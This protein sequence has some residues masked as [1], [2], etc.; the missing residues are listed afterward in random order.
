[1]FKVYD[2]VNDDSYFLEFTFG[3]FVIFRQYLDDTQLEEYLCDFSIVYV[4]LYL[5]FYTSQ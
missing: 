5:Q 4:S 1:M 3:A 2:M